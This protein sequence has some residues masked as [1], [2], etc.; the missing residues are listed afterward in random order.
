MTIIIEKENKQMNGLFVAG[1]NL[2][3]ALFLNACPNSL[4]S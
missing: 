2:Q 1:I 4:V 3:A